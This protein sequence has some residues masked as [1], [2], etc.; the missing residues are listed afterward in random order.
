MQ[1][2]TKA[3]IMTRLSSFFSSPKSLTSFILILVILVSHIGLSRIQFT[4]CL[5]QLQVQQANATAIT[6]AASA[7][8]IVVAAIPD[9]ATTPIANQLANSASYTIIALSALMLERFIT[10]TAPLISFGYLIPIACIC[11]LLVLWGKADK[12]KML[13]LTSHLLVLAISLLLLIPVSLGFDSA[14]S[15]ALDTNEVFESITAESE[16]DEA[17]NENQSIF[18]RFRDGITKT[19]SAI[20]DA[21]GKAVELLNKFMMGVAAMIITTCLIPII[22]IIILWLVLKWAFTGIIGCLPGNLLV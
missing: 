5:E 2:E 22:T 9:D 7:A 14:L 19:F 15:H 6:A 21:T 11:L 12:K 13:R 16:Q 8:S 4:N 1:H 18:D 3:N 10:L 17:V 20:T